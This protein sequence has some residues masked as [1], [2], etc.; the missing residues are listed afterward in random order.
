M[1]INW[2]VSII[3]ALSVIFFIGACQGTTTVREY[4][5]Y[6]LA[7]TTGVSTYIIEDGER[8]WIE[9]DKNNSNRD[10]VESL[11]ALKW[12]VLYPNSKGKIVIIGTFDKKTYGQNLKIPKKIERGVGYP[13]PEPV[14][15]FKL[16]DW[17]LNAPFEYWYADEKI[18]PADI[19][20]R[21]KSSL[22]KDDFKID[23]DNP[24]R[25]NGFND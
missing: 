6:F 11:Y 8:Y 12:N 4:E 13:R 5:Y 21:S 9:F 18:D 19:K 22:D 20:I 23:I 24:E 15:L 1:V 3:S 25:Y 17:Y 2:R 16:Q 10:A 14:G 7:G